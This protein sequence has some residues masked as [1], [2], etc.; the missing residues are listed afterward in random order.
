MWR[1]RCAG[2]IVEEERLVRR[3]GFLGAN[4]L[5]GLVS[6]IVVEVVVR[7][8]QV[9]FH[10]IGPVEDRGPPLVRLGSDEPVELFEAQPGG[11]EIE[12]AGHAV[13][14]V[15]HVVVLAE[16]GGVEPLLPEDL[17]HRGSVLAHKAVVAGIAGGEFHDEAG[18]HR[19]VIAAS[20]QRGPRG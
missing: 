17:R 19:V 13:M 20:E 6:E 5:D 7:V 9:G 1:V 16:P 2:R 18:V 11:P 12:R 15:G 4:P 14:P 3:H 8:A 10:G